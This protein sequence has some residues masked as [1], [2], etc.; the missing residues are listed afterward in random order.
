MER[1]IKLADVKAAVSKAYD[2]FKALNEGTPCGCSAPENKGKFGISLR[3]ADGTKFD[4]GDTQ[5]Q[6]P[7]GD[8]QEIPVFTQL[9]TQFSAAEFTDKMSC[10][11]GSQCGCADKPAKPKHAHAKCLRAISMVQ[12]AGDPEGKMGMIS[13]LMVGMMGSSPVFNDALYQKRTAKTAEADVI[14]TL[15]AAGYE[16]YDDAALTLDISNKLHT[17]LVTTEQ[18]AEMG[19]TIAADGV[20]PVTKQIVFDGSISSSI[21]AIMAAMGPHHM[22]KRWLIITGVPAMSGKGGGFVA[23]IP[24]FGSIAAFAPEL[25]EAGIPIKAALS[26]KQIVN[27]LQLNVFGSARVE[28]VAD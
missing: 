17:M 26:I 7:M 12:P 18:L 21:T 3:L 20:N 10:G 14:N 15:A 11:C 13:D 5:V 25:N 22:K 1:K 16:L 27:M 6:F 24:G 19:A 28:V 23:V 8:L 4:V 9:L 2:D